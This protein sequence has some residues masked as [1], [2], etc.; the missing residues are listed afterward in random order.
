MKEALLKLMHGAGAFAPFRVLNRGRALV[1]MYHRF[2]A[3]TDDAGGAKM[4]ARAFADQLDYLASRYSVVPVSEIAARVRRGEALPRGAAAI[5]IDDGYRDAHAV[6]FPLLRERN[7]PATLYVATGFLDGACWLWTDKM[8]YTLARTTKLQFD[9]IVGGESLRLSLDGEASR[10]AAA[11]RVNSALK[12]MKDEEK[13]TTITRL[14]ATLGVELPER[15][16]AEFAPLSWDEAR[17]MDA[18]GV[19]IAS[20]TIT[21]PILTRV[22][23]EHLR[24]ELVG[25][26]ARLEVVLG[27]AV[28]NF[29]YPDGGFDARVRAEAERAGYSCAVTTAHALVEA[30]GGDPLALAR[31]PAQ[32]QLAR[33]VRDTC[34]LDQTR[35][36]L[37]R[38]RAK[39][40]PN[41]VARESAVVAD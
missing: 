7:L 35:A 24:R 15:P 4:P 2:V 37:S 30:G 11:S 23:D 21:H 6:A 18:A 33:F 12:K 19:E 13:E 29:C 9:E 10:R 22:G 20:H 3:G 32:P 16:P 25:S 14:A 39:L 1:V 8:R 34:G 26:K 28:E 5:T 17:E 36:R 40:P 38:S 41:A 31:I 27:R